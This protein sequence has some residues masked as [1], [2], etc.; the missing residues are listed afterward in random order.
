ML[1]TLNQAQGLLFDR[2]DELGDGKDR[3]VAADAAERP[4]LVT[5][6]V[7]KPSSPGAK[8]D[9]NRSGPGPDKPCAAS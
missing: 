9:G 2:D 7:T 8:E 6:E 3:P 1:R 5:E 4:P